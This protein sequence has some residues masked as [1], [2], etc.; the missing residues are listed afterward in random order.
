MNV[1]EFKINGVYCLKA[2]QTGLFVFSKD[3][4]D[5]T[6]SFVNNMGDTKDI[7]YN[8]LEEVM[9]Y[10]DGFPEEWNKS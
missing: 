2:N 9:E 5:G 3:N 10:S 7:P 6:G 4:G 1:R 8:V